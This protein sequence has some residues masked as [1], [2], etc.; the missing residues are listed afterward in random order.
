[1]PKRKKRLKWSES[2]L[3][4]LDAGIAYYTERNP[5]AA[6][7][8]LDEINRAALS[9]IA[10]TLPA[11]GKAGRVPG[12]RELVLS[13]RTPLHTRFPRSG[14]RFLRN[15]NSAYAAH[16]QKISLNCHTACHSL[17]YLSLVYHPDLQN[18]S[19]VRLI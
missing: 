4:E 8:M 19:N 18:Y 13:A 14:Y 11:K 17:K 1:M 3:A 15:T 9:L 12:T 2:A 5:I 16:R 7:R 6:Q 10:A